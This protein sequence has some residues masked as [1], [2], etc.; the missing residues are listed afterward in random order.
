M[1][2]DR[3]D[4]ETAALLRAKGARVDHMFVARRAVRRA[5]GALI[6]PLAG[7]H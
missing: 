2:I 4:G 1:A 7:A 6:A 5:A 3:D